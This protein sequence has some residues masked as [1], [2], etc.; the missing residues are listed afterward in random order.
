M[1][2]RATRQRLL[3]AAQRL[4]E[5]GGFSRLTTK[6][7]A[8]EA[9]CAEGTLFKHFATKDDLCLAVVLENVPHFQQVLRDKHA[10]AG[11]VEQNLEDIARE[12]I[13]FS[14]KLIPLAASI[15]ADTTLLVRHRQALRE[16][17]GPK[18]AFDLIAKYVAEE[19]QAGHIRSDAAP[20]LVSAL[21]IGPCFYWAFVRQM[22]GQNILPMSDR[23]FA[24]GLVTTLTRGLTSASPRTQR[25]RMRRE[26]SPKRT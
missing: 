15:F 10:G 17:D 19:Q 3:D 4:I 21:L 23:D 9:E 16:G 24:V 8:R 13:L 1:A 11:S 14:K 6:E 20:L 22:L 12:A 25:D 18:E 2:P 26:R 5:T 7:I